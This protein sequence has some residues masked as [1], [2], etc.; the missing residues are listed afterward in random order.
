MPDGGVSAGFRGDE[1]G[2]MNTGLMTRDCR[3][4]G[5]RW[6]WLPLFCWLLNGLL[7]A[8][9][10]RPN[11]ILIIADD[12]GYEDLSF[13]GNPHIHTPNLARLADEGT[14]FEQTFLT[15]ASC[16]SS[17]AS[18]ITGRYPHNNGCAELS[19]GGD[20]DDWVSFFEGIDF[21]PDHLQRAGYYTMQAGKWHIGDSHWNQP[22]GAAAAFFDHTEGGN[23]QGS[24]AERWVELLR[25]RPRQKPFFAWFA[26]HDPHWPHTATE[27]GPYQGPYQHS[28]EEVVL[29]PFIPDSPEMRD[30]FIRYYD[31]IAR[32]D[33]A[34]GD[35]LAELERQGIADQT[36]VIF[37]SDN[38]RPMPRCK[39]FNYDSGM[40]TPL[41]FWGP[42]VLPSQGRRENLVSSL[43]LAPTL[44]ELAGVQLRSANTFQGYSLVP[45]L[46]GETE[47]ADW[48][49]VFSERN[50]HIAPAHVR[51]VRDD[52]F[53]YM[54]N[55]WPHLRR[56]L[57]GEG[58]WEVPPQPAEEFYDRRADPHQ[59]R[60]LI[61][62]P[63]Y[64]QLVARYRSWLDEWAAS[65][66]DR[67][68]ETPTPEWEWGEP[69]WG[70][71]GDYPGIPRFG[72]PVLESAEAAP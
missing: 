47:S 72:L 57:A 54:R 18:L 16:S 58:P 21:F 4:G 41:I 3:F 61:D 45:L 22:G 62:N 46:Q 28:P 36:V 43:D 40:R 14:F 26:S 25:E 20:P 38:G 34:I 67:V 2:A 37:L 29:P 44:C 52:R 48:A 7:Q 56:N 13:T 35:L 6:R 24:G 33:A 32:L 65:T 49:R 9:S 66:G 64:E 39:L 69:G 23:A 68:P 71:R 30:R 53:L 60:N 8:T 55:A 15:T 51:S 42:G 1:H 19:P 12:L 5:G 31:E 59:M 50:W 70:V 27:P 63:D 11:L 17:R 10:E